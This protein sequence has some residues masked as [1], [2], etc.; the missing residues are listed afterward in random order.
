[1]SIAV[2]PSATAMATAA[3]ASSAVTAR[4]SMGHRLVDADGGTDCPEMFRLSSGRGIPVR[5]QRGA[6]QLCI[7]P[8]VRP[9]HC[10]SEDGDVIAPTLLPVLSLQEVTGHPIGPSPT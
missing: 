6:R 2:A 3:P 9:A 1:M 7:E 10:D 5:R 4:H 8:E